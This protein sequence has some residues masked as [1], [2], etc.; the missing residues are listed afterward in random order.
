MSILKIEDAEKRF[1]GITAVNGVSLDVEEKEIVGLIGSNGAGKTTLFNIITGFLEPDSGKIFFKDER[2][3]TLPPYQTARLGLVRTFQIT[4]ALSRMTVMENMLL[5]PKD[6]T[7]ESW[8]RALIRGPKVR[9]EER[10]HR[11]KAESILDF[12]D[13]SR[14]KDEYSGALSGGQKKLLE[15]A[16]ALMLDPDLVLLDEPFAGVNPTLKNKLLEYIRNLRDDGITFVVIEHDIPVI[17]E[18]TDHL[19]VMDEG[20]I[21]AKG[22]LEE[23]KENERVLE[24]YL[25]EEI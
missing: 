10:E 6:Q 7:G 5:G 16:R 12:F 19:F 8:W 25:G 4:R 23:I 22:S 14:M 18:I 15:L 1:G 2:I 17:N 9:E 13:L 11:E 3:D 24:T 20:I 21:I